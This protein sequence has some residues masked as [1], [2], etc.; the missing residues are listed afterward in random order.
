MEHIRA[1]RAAAELQEPSQLGLHARHDLDGV[2]GLCHIVVRPGSEAEDFVVVL[3][4]CR[5]QNDGDIGKLAQ[6]LHGMK[7]IQPRHHDIEQHKVDLL[8][9]QGLER[10]QTV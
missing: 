8:V 7:T 10:L 3:G 4:F 9:A 5:K 6:A 1:N 2:K